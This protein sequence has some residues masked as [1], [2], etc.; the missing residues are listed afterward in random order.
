M[1]RFEVWSTVWR[2]KRLN[3]QHSSRKNSVPLVIHR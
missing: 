2:D 3:L 1:L